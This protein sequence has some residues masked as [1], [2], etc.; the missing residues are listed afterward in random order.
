MRAET[1]AEMEKPNLLLFC[2]SCNFL[3]FLKLN[4]TYSYLL[5]AC[6]SVRILK[7]IS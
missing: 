2:F 5:S 3:H 6:V 4:E 1:G 7:F